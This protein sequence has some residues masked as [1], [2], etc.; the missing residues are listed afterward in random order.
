MYVQGTSL[1]P[2]GSVIA[3]FLAN[4][5]IF[6]LLESTKLGHIYPTSS[7]F[8][9]L[10]KN[11]VSVAR[12]IHEIERFFIDTPRTFAKKLSRDTECYVYTHGL[13]KYERERY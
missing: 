6:N 12:N 11:I 4:K 8:L 13:G 7:L 2:S 1:F 10:I 5:C 3:I 9:F